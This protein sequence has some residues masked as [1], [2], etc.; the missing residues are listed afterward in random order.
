[1][2]NYLKYYFNRELINLIYEI[3]LQPICLR[4]IL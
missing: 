2:I 4:K 1:M 3:F